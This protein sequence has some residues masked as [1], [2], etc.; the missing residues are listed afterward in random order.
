M[1]DPS[2]LVYISDPA[3]WEWPGASKF[4]LVRLCQAT[5]GAGPLTTRGWSL[6]EKGALFLTQTFCASKADIRRTGR[7]GQH[8]TDVITIRDG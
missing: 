7:L 2:S 4:R 8:R 3:I 6:R 1:N 5:W